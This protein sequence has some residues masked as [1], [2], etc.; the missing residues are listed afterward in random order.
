MKKWLFISLVF[1]L[2]T[3]ISC[4]VY[5]EKLSYKEFC[6]DHIH[7]ILTQCIKD[8]MD[9]SYSLRSF[10]L[11]SCQDNCL[12]TW[13]EKIMKCKSDF[14]DKLLQEDKTLAKSN[15][16]TKG[17]ESCLYLVKNLSQSKA[18]HSE[19][20][21]AI[22]CCSYIINIEWD[23]VGG[24]RMHDPKS[25]TIEPNMRGRY[26]MNCTPG[27]KLTGKAT[28]VDKM[29]SE[30]RYG[31]PTSFCEQGSSDSSDVVKKVEVNK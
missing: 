31:Y 16:Q 9:K 12:D 18:L 3:N 29:D 27:S 11:K 17:K 28:R 30:T 20:Y 23:C 25:F 5:A 13:E 6:E 26:D 14:V 7:D 24:K 2:L 22:N 1:I 21:N 15:K 8:C 19:Y 10:N 4:F